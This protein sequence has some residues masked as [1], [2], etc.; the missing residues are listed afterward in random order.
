M[1]VVRKNQLVN[2]GKLEMLKTT[3]NWSS[4]ENL[5]LFIFLSL[6]II[7]ITTTTTTTTT[8]LINQKIYRTY[9]SC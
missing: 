9:N 1:I 6:T 2:N 3:K 4:T 7:I 5:K 8:I